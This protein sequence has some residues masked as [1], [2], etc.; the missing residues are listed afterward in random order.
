MQFQLMKRNEEKQ[1]ANF[2]KIFS[3]LI[4]SNDHIAII[5]SYNIDNN[6]MFSSF[7]PIECLHMYKR[8][9]DFSFNKIKI[10]RQDKKDNKKISQQIHKFTLNEVV[11]QQKKE[12][13]IK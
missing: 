3:L 7:I 1:L 6:S 12:L 8:V 13:D 4:I 5:I 9:I 10:N 11:R 2:L